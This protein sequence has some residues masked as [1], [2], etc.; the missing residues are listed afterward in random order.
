MTARKPPY[1][2][3]ASDCPD[4]GLDYLH[5]RCTESEGCLLWT[6]RLDSG[7]ITQIQGRSWKVRHL[8]WNLV[9]A[10]GP[11]K[12]W[13]P[14][15]TV[16]G[17]ARCVHPDHLTLVRRNSAVVGARRPLVHRMNSAKRASGAKLTVQQAQE[18]RASTDIL[19]VLAE[20]YSISKSVAS[21]VRQGTAWKDYRNPFAQLM[22][23]LA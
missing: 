18:I 5:A 22:G 15:P 16:C 2:R 20:R 11:A 13:L 8:V 19:A 12:G 17:N 7:P 9:H 3:P 23:A 1:V 21:R 6:L 4:I 10:R 14:M